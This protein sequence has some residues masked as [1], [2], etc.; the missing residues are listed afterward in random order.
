M[1]CIELS[2]LVPDFFHLLFGMTEFRGS[3]LD[4]M[5]VRLL[6]LE[7]EKQQKQHE[8]LLRKLDEETN[9]GL[10]SVNSKFAGGSDILEEKF[11]AQTVG[12]VSLDEFRYCYLCI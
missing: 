8:E 12:L 2:C 9:R 3:D 5:R 6:T 7:R 1:V 11:K 4:T 10:M